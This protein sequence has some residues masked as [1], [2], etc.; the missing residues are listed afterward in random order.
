MQGGEGIMK[1]GGGLQLSISPLANYVQNTIHNCIYFSE[2]ITG[3]EFCF[4]YFIY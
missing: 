4:S 2:D 1:I 3:Q